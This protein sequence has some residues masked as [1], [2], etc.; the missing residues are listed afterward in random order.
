MPGKE[1]DFIVLDPRATAFAKLRAETSTT[2]Q[3]RLFSLM[4]EEMTAW[5]KLQTSLEFS[6]LSGHGIAC[7]PASPGLW[8]RTARTRI[9]RTHN[10]SA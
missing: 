7:A 1:A 3:G 6:S 8:L 5:S 4:I 9:E 2:L 10:H